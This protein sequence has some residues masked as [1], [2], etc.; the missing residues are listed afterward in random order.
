MSSAPQA[1]LTVENYIDGAW[2]TPG[3]SPLES[4]NPATG[5]LVA[6]ARTSTAADVDRA[7]MV[8]RR[9]FDEGDWRSRAGKERAAVLLELARLLREHA[10]PLAR[11]ISE[12][13]GKPIRYA[14]ER[15]IEPAIDRVLFYA[16]AARLI[17]GEVTMAAPG[18][19]LNLVL[20]EPVGVC[21][22]I[23][24]WNDP[25]DLPLRKIGAALAAGC[26]F[27]LKPA[28]NAPAASMEIFQL[29]DQIGGLPAGV[30]NGVVGSGPEIGEALATDPRVNKISF[31]GSSEVAHR[32]ME[33]ASGTFKRVS[34]EGGGKAPVL[35]FDDANLDK[36]MDAVAVGIFLYAGQS[37]TAG[38]RLLVQRSIKDAFVAGLV[39]RARQLRVGSPLDETTQLGP[40][41]S[42]E[43]LDKVLGYVE[44]GRQEGARLILGGE[45]L[46]GEWADGFYVAPTIF[47][48]VR[49][50][51]AI[52]REEIFGPVLSVMAF[53]TEDEALSLA[54]DSEFGLG[55]AV[56]TSDLDRA[57]RLARGL[58]VGDVWV[59]THYVRL[60]E[61]PFGGVGQSGIG[62]ELGMEGLDEYLE[63]KRVCIDSA[64]TF[65]IR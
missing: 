28:S 14:R 27:V 44:R 47:D 9:A 13:M 26:T 18:H 32:L 43:Q 52:A 21:A 65:H 57:I 10:E 30:A 61:S 19:Q 38:S 4:R 41:V 22:L 33:L 1:A 23:T 45:R 29:L 36:A 35:V 25:V 59:N 17:H 51:M 62:R 55:S 6:T 31:T 15:E 12:E 3:G 24:P 7:V 16:G 56:W 42:R 49:P 39:E 2:Q 46:N 5:E 63:S 53:D 8:A 58:R 34:L 48:E 50:E 54:N 20:K 64:P 60:A 11:L 37:C 40:M